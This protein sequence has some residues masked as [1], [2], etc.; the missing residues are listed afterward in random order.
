MSHRFSGLAVFCCFLANAHEPENLPGSEKESLGTQ[1]WTVSDYKGTVFEMIGE[2][3][4]GKAGSGTKIGFTDPGN[5]VRLG[6]K[7]QT[8]GQF[9]KSCRSGKIR[10]IPGELLDRA[11]LL[12]N[13][14]QDGD[15]QVGWPDREEV[16]A[17]GLKGVKKLRLGYWKCYQGG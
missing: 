14:V 2:C 7:I 12:D 13:K 16:G 15:T 5:R 10:A 8:E 17:S 9:D 4:G 1:G 3:A 6:L 11:V